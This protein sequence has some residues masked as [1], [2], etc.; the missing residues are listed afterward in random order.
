MPRIG[1]TTSVMSLITIKE[2]VTFNFAIAFAVDIWRISI[3][4]TSLKFSK[5]DIVISYNAKSV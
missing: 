5:L 1:E 4:H 3:H 2:I